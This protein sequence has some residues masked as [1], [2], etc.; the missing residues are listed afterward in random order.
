LAFQHVHRT[1]RYVPS[2]VQGNATNA[3]TA[4]DSTLLTLRARVS[5]YIVSLLMSSLTV[6]FNFMI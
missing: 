3:P 2:G 4:M 5:I 6:C 1:A